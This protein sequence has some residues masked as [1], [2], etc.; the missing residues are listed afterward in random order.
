MEKVTPCLWFD[1]QAEEAAHFYVSVFPNSRIGEISRVTG[2]GRSE[3]GSVLTI[4]FELDGR[5]FLGLNGGPAFKFNEA[6][7][8][9]V[10]C[11]DQPEVDFYWE[12]LSEG[13]ETSQCGW[14]KDRFGVSWQIVPRVLMELT[15]DP[16]MAKAQRVTEAMLQMTKLD[17]AALERAAAA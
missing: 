4:A 11:G 7:S 13:G 16:D 8:F 17:I 12:K 3:P 14:L 9:M 15:R 2:A 5:P 1:G 6:V 10:D